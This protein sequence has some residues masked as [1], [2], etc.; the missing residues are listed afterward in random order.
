[1]ST[2]LYQTLGERGNFFSVGGNIRFTAAYIMGPTNAKGIN[3]LTNK[4]YRELIIEL[5]TTKM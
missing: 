3:I 5:P 4:R 2:K 1:L